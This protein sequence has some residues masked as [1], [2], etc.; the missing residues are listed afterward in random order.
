M[1]GL[2]V[3]ASTFQRSSNISQA[4]ADVNM[5]TEVKQYILRIEHCSLS[6]EDRKNPSH[7]AIVY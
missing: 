4:I 1:Y 7:S 3:V 2:S 5:E 6:I